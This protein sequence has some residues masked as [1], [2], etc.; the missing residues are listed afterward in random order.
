MAC[1]MILSAALYTTY[2]FSTYAVAQEA[3]MEEAANET[4]TCATI[5]A[6][7]ANMTTS[8]L[9]PASIEQLNPFV[10][11]LLQQG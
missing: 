7:Q 1:L 8:I 3:A 5:E 2:H 11:S 9:S 6:T 4:V 10:S